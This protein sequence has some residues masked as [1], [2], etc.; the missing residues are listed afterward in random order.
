MRF[1][2]ITIEAAGNFRADQTG[3]IVMVVPT[4]GEPAYV[5]ALTQEG[6]PWMQFI[7]PVNAITGQLGAIDMSVNPAV[8]VPMARYD[9]N[10]TNAYVDLKIY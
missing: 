8:L 1:G 4:G 5:P 9:E 6:A 10:A 2:T 7:V 3:N